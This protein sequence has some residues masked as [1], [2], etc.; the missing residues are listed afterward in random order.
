MDLEERKEM[1]NLNVKE[2]ITVGRNVAKNVSLKKVKKSLDINMKKK[3]KK[4]K[5]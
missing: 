3:K 5:K 2:E 4:K 1:F